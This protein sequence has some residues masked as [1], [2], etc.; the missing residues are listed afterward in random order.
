MV[1]RRAA[2]PLVPLRFFR[3]RPRVLANL[4]TALLSAAL[5]TS[6]LLF[7][8]YL[9]DQLGLSPLEADLTML[10]LAVA[11]IAASV[12]VPQLLGRWGAQVCTLAGIGFTVLAMA[13]LALAT[14]LEA[15]ALAMIPAMLLIAA[16][17][18]FGLVGLQYTAVTGVTENDAGIASGIQR[19]AD[20]LGGSTGTTLYVGI[21]FAPALADIDPFLT[22]SLLAVAGLTAAGV[23]AWRIAMPA[24]PS[25]ETVG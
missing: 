1:E 9:Q 10:P 21:G 14:H 7:T 19:A 6:F 17:M 11:L 16:G 15:N 2:N 3:S 25:E 12:F 20:Q 24:S 13:S 23:V 4:A 18:G 8:Y 5:S 22:S